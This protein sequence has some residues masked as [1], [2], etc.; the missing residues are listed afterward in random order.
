MIVPFDHSLRLCKKNNFVKLT[1]L[2]V[3]DN[4]NQFIFDVVFN[5]KTDSYHQFEIGKKMVFADLK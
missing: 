2:F 3:N 4:F 5:F 1:L